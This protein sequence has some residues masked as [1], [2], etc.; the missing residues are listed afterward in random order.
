MDRSTKR[1]IKKNRQKHKSTVLTDETSKEVVETVAQTEILTDE[2]CEDNVI[3]C[4][5]ELGQDDTEEGDAEE[6][7]A[8]E[9]ET[10]K[11]DTEENDEI[12]EVSKE[13]SDDL[14]G[15]GISKDEDFIRGT[16]GGL[17]VRHADIVSAVETSWESLS[18]KVSSETIKAI[19]EGM[20]YTNMMPIQA[21]AIPH[22]LTGKDVLA[23]ARTG[24]GKTLAFLVPIIELITKLKFMNRNGTGA[25]IL[26][27][28][29][30]LA[31]QTFGVLKELMANHSQTF[32]LVMG[33]SDRKAESKKLGNGV[34]I[35]VATPGRLLDHLQNTTNFMVKNLMCLCVD[36]AD[37]IL[38]VGFEDEMKAIVKLLPKKR[39]TMLF[40]A[41]QTKKTEDLARISL[42]KMPVYIGVDDLKETATV[43]HLEQGYIVAESDA[44]LRILYTFLKRNKTKKIMVFFSSCMSVKFHYELFNYIDIPT[45]SI[46][47]K[48]KQ[49]KRT[50]TYFQFCNA[51]TG[52][53]FCTDVAARG[54]D[55]PEVDWIV[56][57]DPPDDPKDYIH[58]VGRACRGES[59]NQGHAL[60]FLR[61]QEIGFLLYLKKSK[62]PVSEFQIQSSKVADIQNQLE[63]LLKSNYYLHQSSREGY[64]SYVRAYASHS[65]RTVFD[66]QSLDL[67][68]VSKSF[69]FDTPPWV[70][71][72]V[73]GVKR[74]GKDGRKER[75]ITK[76]KKKF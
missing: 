58:R 2:I 70:D 54:L 9:N 42:K 49:T 12:G 74:K 45:M 46:H 26:S 41:T 32:G 25:I 29:R 30:E 33:G 51:E 22:L 38:E 47:G 76:R 65:L 31:L 18:D 11:N 62:V 24:S 20:G 4:P 52:I 56:Q 50:S 64:K 16:H 60:L 7:D 27:P 14:I 23:A 53:L 61:P 69:A 37:R 15:D 59:K 72:G 40:S 6:N 13:E 5:P 66:V 17:K 57:Y 28:T 44:R 36:E 68:K 73:A 1:Q 10:E 35:I 75:M 43:E 55:I 48:Q 71:I 39:Q 19:T 3:P 21:R 34:N 63:Q 8:E 67:K